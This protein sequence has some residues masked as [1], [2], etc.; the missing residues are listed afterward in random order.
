MLQL[1]WDAIDHVAVWGM[2]SA[3]LLFGEGDAIGHIAVW[4]MPSAILL[5]GE[6]DAIGHIAVCTPSHSLHFN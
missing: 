2:P 5:L 1:G 6:G 3:I 4:G